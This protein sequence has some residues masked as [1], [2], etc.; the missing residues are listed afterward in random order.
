MKNDIEEIDLKSAKYHK[1][2]LRFDLG[3]I[4]YLKS[5][6]NKKCPMVISKILI[7]DEDYDYLCEWATSQKDINSRTFIDKILSNGDI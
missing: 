3:E 4:V 6:S 1:K 5:D 2:W 7:L